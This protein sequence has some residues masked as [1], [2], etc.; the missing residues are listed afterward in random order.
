MSITKQWKR[1]NWIISWQMNTENTIPCDESN[2]EYMSWVRRCYDAIKIKIVFRVCSVS[3]KA[4]YIVH[5]L[6]SAHNLDGW[7]RFHRRVNA[8]NIERQTN[9]STLVWMC[10]R[11]WRESMLQF[12][13]MEILNWK[14][15]CFFLG[16]NRK[17]RNVPLFG[18]L[19]QTEIMTEI[20]CENWRIRNVVISRF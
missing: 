3:E 11:T 5:C 17:A 2:G 4:N 18:E 6:F 1:Q 19:A 16:F 12:G 8:I 13:W 9:E 20:P 10:E 14:F 15:N 7:N